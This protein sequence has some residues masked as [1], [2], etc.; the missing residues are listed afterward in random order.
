MLSSGE[1]V[2]VERAECLRLLSSVC[3]GRVV[4]TNAALPAALPVNYV[5]DGEEVVFR[6][7]RGGQL[8]TAVPGKVVGFEIDRIDV[9]TC[10]GWSVL[11]VGE[12][13]EVNAPAR[14]ARLARRW[15]EPWAP[16]RTDVVVSIPVQLLSG[17]RI[18]RGDGADGRLGLAM[19]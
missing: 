9:V 11:G 12:A 7:R 6:T 13:Y 8:A 18:C 14:L 3:V 17:R 5:L 4:F 16:G 2:E 19:T 1:M 15:P 10:T